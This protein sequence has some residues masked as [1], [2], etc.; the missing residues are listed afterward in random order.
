M[1][2]SEFWKEVQKMEKDAVGWSPMLLAWTWF[3]KTIERDYEKVMADL[4][5]EQQEHQPFLNLS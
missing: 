1:T 3:T 5:S 2:R 4:R